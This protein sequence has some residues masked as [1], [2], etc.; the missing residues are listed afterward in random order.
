MLDLPLGGG[1]ESPSLGAGAAELAALRRCACAGWRFGR[2]VAARAAG[3]ARFSRAGAVSAA[4]RRRG[5]SRRGSSRPTGVS[6]YG[7]S[8]HLGS[9][10]SAQETQGYFTRARQLG[11]RKYRFSIG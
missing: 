2:F 11:Q 8:A 1:F 3:A 5:A 6:Q 4:A 7:H 10:G 9:T